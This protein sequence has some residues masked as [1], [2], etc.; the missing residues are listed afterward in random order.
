MNIITKTIT[1]KLPQEQVFDYFLNNLNDWWPKAYTWSKQVLEEIKI[2]P[3]IGGLCT[4]TGPG[5]FRCDWGRVIDL[6]APE[7]LHLKWQ[8]NPQRVP[9]PDPA[10]ASDVEIAFRQTSE[11]ETTIELQHFNFE[12][13]QQGAQQYYEGMNAAQGWAF[14]LHEFASYLD[15]KKP[16]L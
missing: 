4:E 8:I 11:T 3:F 15:N 13:H 6:I 5:G 7:R 16:S 12:N 1:V 2:E 14:I 9:E 10:K